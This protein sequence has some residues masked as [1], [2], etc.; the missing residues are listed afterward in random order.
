MANYIHST[1]IRVFPSIGRRP[2]YDNESE[3]T[4]ENNLSQI[5]RSLSPGHRESFVIS[6][7]VDTNQP[8]EF[9]LYGFYF[10]V[11]DVTTLTKMLPANGSGQ[12][13]AGIKTTKIETSDN[14]SVIY[15]LLTIAN[16]EGLEP[17]GSLHLLDSSESELDSD[18]Q[19]VCFGASEED[20]KQHLGS[21]T[22]NIHVLQL[23]TGTSGEATIP[24]K[25]LLH[26]R[27][28]EIL[29]SDTENYI[30]STFT[31]GILT[32][33]TLTTTDA[34]IGN[35]NATSAQVGNI[36]LNGSTISTTSG[37]ITF[38]NA[39]SAGN[40]TLRDDSI[41]TGN[42]SGNA[43]T[44]TKFHNAAT[45]SLT[46]DITGSSSS[47]FGWQLNT[48]INNNAVTTDKINDGAVTASKVDQ[49]TFVTVTPSDSDS[50]HM[51]LNIFPPTTL[52]TIST[53]N[54]KRSKK[55][56]N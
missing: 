41:L 38:N 11:L 54:V 10:K 50:E 52:N 25:S 37:P 30:S 15:Q 18:F 19:G 3:L 9:I 56:S 20:I 23:L 5:V 16:G 2:Q 27:T 21:D 14:T 35:L 12:L 53:R 17:P 34:T 7:K 33:S 44:T 45:I 8:F 49:A 46:G 43:S 47:T 40:I 51:T 6:R 39:I 55:S 13:W 29:D 24:V 28:D 42:V 48:T 32:T 26:T 4:N 22:S 36:T 31:T 1:D